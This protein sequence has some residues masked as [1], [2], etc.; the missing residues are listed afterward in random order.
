MSTYSLN[1]RSINLKHFVHYFNPFI[2]FL[3]WQFVII[4]YLEQK[5]ILKLNQHQYEL[6]ASGVVYFALYSGLI[7]WPLAL[8]QL[9][10]GLYKWWSLD[11]TNGKIFIFPAITTGIMY[12]CFILAS[13]CGLSIHP[14]F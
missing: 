14:G 13:L 12:I 4:L 8:L 11:L 6:I 5:H 3:L 10:Y 7:A 1:S 2:L 9:C